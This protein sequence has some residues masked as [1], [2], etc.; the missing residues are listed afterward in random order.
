MKVDFTEGKTRLGDGD[1]KYVD[2]FH[3]VGEG[4]SQ[5]QEE[6]PTAEDEIPWMNK[7]C[8]LIESQRDHVHQRTKTQV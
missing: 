5:G 4:Q 7:Y 2:N 6:D 1:G 8:I 3:S